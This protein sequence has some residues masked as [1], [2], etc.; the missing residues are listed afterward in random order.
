MCGIPFEI[1]LALRQVKAVKVPAA[2]QE[3]KRR[4]PRLHAAGGEEA[5]PFG[6]LR[7]GNVQPFGHELDPQRRE[8][9]LEVS[10]HADLAFGHRCG[11]PLERVL[12]ET[13]LGHEQHQPH[14]EDRADQHEHDIAQDAQGAR[15]V[16]IAGRGFPIVAVERR[17]HD[18]AKRAGRP[19]GCAAGTRRATDG[20]NFA[21]MWRFAGMN[22]PC[23]LVSLP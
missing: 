20:P 13:A 2:E 21:Q 4:D 17:V 22:V 8:V 14:R 15:P 5:G 16:W 19:F 1:G 12:E 7:V 6:P 3:R 23:H 18:A 10:A 9:E 11:D